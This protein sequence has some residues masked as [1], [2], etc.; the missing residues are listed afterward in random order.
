MTIEQPSLTIRHLEW[1]LQHDWGQDAQ[2]KDGTISEL[3]DDWVTGCTI[4]FTNIKDLKA[5]AGY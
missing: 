1:A 2:L 4:S 5:W 3:L